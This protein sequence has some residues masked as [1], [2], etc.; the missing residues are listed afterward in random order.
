[1][2]CQEFHW[3]MQH[4]LSMQ[5]I[6]MQISS[7]GD[8]ACRPLHGGNSQSSMRGLPS[9]HYVRHNLLSLLSLSEYAVEN[10]TNMALTLGLVAETS[11]SHH[12][13]SCCCVLSSLL[14]DDLCESA[15][16]EGLHCFFS[17]QSCQRSWLQP[18]SLMDGR[19]SSGSLASCLIPVDHRRFWMLSMIPG[20]LAEH[21]QSKVQM[22]QTTCLAS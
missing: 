5:T 2:I 16:E 18:S 9:M 12:P 13:S 19:P 20:I 11:Y 15:S 8:R 3:H 1:M 6:S 7:C 10:V 17:V 4:L 14:R 21:L 22:H